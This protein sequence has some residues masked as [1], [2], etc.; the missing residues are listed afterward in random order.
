M[1]P[2]AD[3]AT[4]EEGENKAS[5]LSENNRV[6]ICEEPTCRADGDERDEC[7]RG[8]SSVAAQHQTDADKI[9]LLVFV[10]GSTVR[11]SSRRSAR[12]L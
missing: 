10:S 7:T 4:R 9:F 2:A 6:N 11:M 12:T 1:E 3:T 5:Q 8:S